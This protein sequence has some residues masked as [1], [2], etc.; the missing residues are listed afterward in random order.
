M[1]TSPALRGVLD[2]VAKVADTDST[3]L[4]T[5]ESGT[6]KELIARAIHYN[7]RRGA[8]VSSPSTAAPFPRS[9]SSPSSSATC[10]GPSPTP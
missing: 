5:G 6:G 2:V 1:G 4:I 7:S 8:D 9:C 10:A 3:V